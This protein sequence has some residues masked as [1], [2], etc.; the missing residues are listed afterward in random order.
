MNSFCSALAF[1]YLC[2]QI[3][4]LTDE[5]IIPYFINMLAG[6]DYTGTGTYRQVDDRGG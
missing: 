4:I 2:A 1:L 6:T 3:M 5:T